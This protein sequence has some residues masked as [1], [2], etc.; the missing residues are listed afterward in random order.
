MFFSRSS[1]YPIGLDISDLSLK[2]IQLRKRGRKIKIKAMGRVKLPA[3]LIE[4]GIIRDKDQVAKSIVKL[5]SSPEVGK[6]NTNEVVVCLPEAKTFLKLIEID[7]TENDDDIKDLI[8]QEV[9]KHIPMKI[10]EIYYDWQLIRNLP[11]KQLILVGASPKK[12]IDDYAETLSRAKLTV[13]AMEPEPIS[14]CRCLIPDESPKFKRDG[15]ENYG[16]ID[17]GATNASLTVYAQT[18]IVFTSSMPISGEK[19]TEKIAEAL[20]VKKEKAEKTKIIYSL[21]ESEE[22][23][24]DVNKILSDMV[25]ELTSKFK[26]AISFYNKNYS[27]W[28]KIDKILLCGGGANFKNLEKI[29]SIETNIETIRGDALINLG[30]NREKFLNYFQKAYSLGTKLTSKKIKSNKKIKVM[31][32][33][34][35]LSPTFAT[36]IGLALR[37][38]FIKKS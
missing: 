14:V 33:S 6:V 20:D 7:K 24:P 10:S 26:E 13:A 4:S 15:R 25:N 9:E 5:V 31:K 30:E 22:E 37:N 23:R 34:Q 19:I 27:H 28:G 12:L 1:A 16:I 21:D 17:I 3:G 2:I 11:K 35:D 8:A 32:V 36:T 29:L 18:T 38:I